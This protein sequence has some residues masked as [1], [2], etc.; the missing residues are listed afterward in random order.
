MTCQCSTSVAR[1]L[2]SSS[3]I[4]PKLLLP[5]F[6][7]LCY[8]IIHCSSTSA[9]AYCVGKREVFVLV[10]SSTRTKEVRRLHVIS[11]GLGIWMVVA[12]FILNYSHTAATANSIVIGL[13]IS[14]F[15]YMR[16]RTFSGTWTSWS[17][18]GAGLWI[19]L[20]PFIFGYSKAGTY[21]NELLLGL[22]L[23]I[24][25]FSALGQDIRHH[26]HLAH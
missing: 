12:P 3:T 26:S 21:W 15:S 14:A 5:R 10:N 18:A 19:V 4:T 13:A 1:T 2:S 20:S 22:V 11:F 7:I 8:E 9:R 25:M 23:I 16:L 6:C 24:L 17:L